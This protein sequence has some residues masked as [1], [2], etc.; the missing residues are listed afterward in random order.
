MEVT[1]KRSLL[2][3][4]ALRRARRRTF[5]P[6]LF[7]LVAVAIAC[8][9]GGDQTATP[10]PTAARPVTPTA[11][12]ST[13]QVTATAALTPTA[14]PTAAS[15]SAPVAGRTVTLTVQNHG[16]GMEGHTPRGFRGSGTGIFVGDNLNRSFPNGDGVQA[17]LTFDL[18]DVPR[19]RVVSAI[20]RSTHGS[21]RGSPY[22]DLGPLAAEEIRYDAFSPDLWNLET[23]PGGVRCVL[24]TSADS[25]VECGVLEAVQR[26][27]DDGYRAAQFRLRLERAG[28]GDGS[29][30]MAMFFITDSNTNEPGI[31]ELEIAV[32]TAGG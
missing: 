2:E 3:P 17:F 32:D 21:T 23:L 16:G 29:P 27:L 12:P 14:A 5:F 15:P 8:S 30:D 20:F 19:G 7:G 13:A 22:R 26:S 9:G 1:L 25:P 28:D 10:A 11:T 31:F 18:T 24:A 4:D 6:A